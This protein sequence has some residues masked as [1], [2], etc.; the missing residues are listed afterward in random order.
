MA[1]T[2]NLES[3]VTN[4]WVIDDD[5]DP[6]RERLGSSQYR[7][8]SCTAPRTRCFHRLMPRRWPAKYRVLASSSSKA[9][10]MNSP[11]RSGT[12]PSPRSGQSPAETCAGSTVAGVITIER[13]V[14][15]DKPVETVFAYLSDF[16][17]TTE[18]DPG[19][20]STVKVEGDGGPGTKYQNNS[21]FAGRETELEYVV[22]QLE[23]GQIFQLRGENKTVSALDTM[24]FRPADG[25]HR[26][27]VPGRVRVQGRDPADR[28]A[29]QEPV[30]EARRR[31]RAGDARGAGQAVGR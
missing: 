25:G 1:R 10:A 14:T 17:T 28:A 13:V 18:W 30:Q 22:Q 19:T 27:D 21:S 12:S 26:G 7:P 8:W 3:A 2:K 23:A 20:V 9:P 24:T 16:E 31:G 15:V 5:G 29:V 4:H 11:N 6:V